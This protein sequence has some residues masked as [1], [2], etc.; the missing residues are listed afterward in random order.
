MRLLWT[1]VGK[2]ERRILICVPVELKYLETTARQFDARLYY[3]KKEWLDAFLK[4]IPATITPFGLYWSYNCVRRASSTPAYHAFFAELLG[5]LRREHITHVIFMPGFLAERELASIKALGIVTLLKLYDDPEASPYYTKQ[6]VRYF[7]KT[8]CSGVSYDGH[9]TI[10]EMIRRWGGKDVRFIPVPPEEGHY[11]LSK[12]D[13]SN[14]DIDIIHIGALNI[15]KW[16]RLHKIHRHF[17]GRVRFFGRYDPRKLGGL[18]GFLHRVINIVWPLPDI[19]A[20]S[21]NAVKTLYR[22]AKIGFNCHLSYGPSNSRSYELCLNG[23]LQ[24]TDNPDGY[25]EL[26][27]VGREIICYHSIREAILL[28]EYY[29]EHEDERVA[30]AKAGYRRARRDYTYE[31]TWRRYLEFLL[32]RNT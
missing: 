13:F 3:V 15:K 29:L 2:G 26:Y 32:A 16:R 5:F 7:D 18:Q 31:R 28:I 6:M 22:R 14:R 12:I 10:A 8:I 24:V 4:T 25:R 23:V 30:I 9:R 11:D 19:E 1:A 20:V 17:S 21:E 27:D